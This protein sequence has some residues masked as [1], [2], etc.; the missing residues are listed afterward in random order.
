MNSDEGE[1]L[2]TRLRALTK[3]FEDG[4]GRI[5]IETIPGEH[6]V[7]PLMIR[8]TA[9]THD[10]VRHLFDNGVLVTGLAYPVVPR[11]DEEIRA[12]V[13]ADHTEADI[14]Y[15]LGVLEAYQG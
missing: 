1:A 13:N 2:L 14:D 3:R 15:V 7:V 12:Q 6:P 10:M 9:K 11:G 4:L 5:G 8:D